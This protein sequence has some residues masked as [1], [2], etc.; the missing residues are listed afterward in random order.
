VVESL[1]VIAPTTVASEVVEPT[2]ITSVSVFPT[3]SQVAGTTSET[4]VQTYVPYLSTGQTVITSVATVVYQPPQTEIQTVGPVVVVGTSVGGGQV[5]TVVQSFAPET[6]VVDHADVPVTHVATPP[7][8]NIVSQVGGTV[9]T[10]YLVVTPTP[11]TR[12]VSLDVASTIG[13]VSRTVV[14]TQAPRTIVTSQDGRLVTLVSTPP[15]ESKVTVVGGTPTTI[16]GELRTV[17]E[18]QAPRTIVT[19]QDGRL[20]TFV[21]TPPPESKVT[22]VGGTPTT[23]GGELRTVVETQAPRTIVTSQDGRLVTFVSTPPPESKV[24]VVGGTLT[25]FPVVST[26]SG[27]QPITYVVTTNSGGREVTLTTVT[28]PTGTEPITLTFA[29]TLS[30]TLTT[31]VQTFAPTTFLSSVSGRLSTIVTTP[32]PSTFLS[33]APL[34]TSTFTSTSAVPSQTETAP[35]VQ[36]SFVVTT[37]TY[38]LSSREYFTGTFL[39]PLLAVAFVIPL[40]IIDLNA[41]LYQPFNSLSAGAS[42]YDAL[43]LQFTGLMG[44]I[45]PAVTLMQ[46]RPVPFVTT[47]MVMFAS[48]MV[49]LAA[50]A[51]S[52]KLHG[53]CNPLSSVGCAAALGVSPTSAHILLALGAAVILLLCLLIFFLRDWSTG[54]HANPWNLAGIA[55]LSRNPDVRIHAA[56]T[57]NGNDNY[58]AA[59][60]RAVADKM[61]ALGY[62]ETP[63]GREE[64]GLLLADDSGRGLSYDNGAEQHQQFGEHDAAPGYLGG[65]EV[66]SLPFMTLRYPWRVCFVLYLVGL[67]VLIAYYD[68]TLVAQVR[69][70]TVARYTS[71][72]L[73][74]DSHDFGIRFLFAGLGV[75][76]TFCWQA[77]FVG[78]LRPSTLLLLA[79]PPQSTNTRHPSTAVATILPFHALSHRLQPPE[80][81]VLLSRP[82]NAFSGIYLAIRQRHPFYIAVSLATVLSEFLPVLL[83]NVPH[84]LTQVLAPTL[85]CTRLSLAVLGAMVL[86]VVWSFFVAWPPMPVDPRSVAGM[87]WYVCESRRLLDDCAGLAEVGGRERERRVREMGRRYFYGDVA[88][89]NGGGRLGVD[90]HVGLEERGGGDDV[91]TEYISRKGGVVVM[92]EREEVMREEVGM[93]QPREVSVLEQRSNV[94]VM[95]QP[96]DVRVVSDGRGYGTVRT[97]EDVVRAV[98]G[99]REDWV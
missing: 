42:G 49:P 10:S 93:D 39:P 75:I 28:T 12:A 18:T 34:T 64:Y 99:R 1:T 95:D 90:V 9:V 7:P 63:D 78:M 50:E 54:L 65:Q 3:T 67:L 85:V 23:I 62:Y 69:D 6:R 66:K 19:S 17:V 46:G 45:T 89:G 83:S 14:E 13:G 20:V 73:S 31:I 88:K 96:R 55:S 68:Y 38:N 30:G 82:T 71:F 77:F 5:F 70:P 41:K 11:T 47:L 58:D 32:S 81:S 16:G 57:G 94:R 37:K 84:K 98:F 29:S 15:P 87:M 59:V 51:V 2:K 61:Y 22:V 91:V 48:L 97:G 72:H 26:S 53:R 33:T 8:Q 35:P 74:L 86:V 25:T 80:R 21:S 56:G 44:F 24:T 27:F 52:L 43:T 60:R 92:E 4:V 79:P 40:R 36:T 76:I